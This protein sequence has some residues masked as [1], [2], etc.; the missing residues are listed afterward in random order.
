MKFLHDKSIVNDR[1]LAS[2]NLRAVNIFDLCKFNMS[3]NMF[4]NTEQVCS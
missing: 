4:M 1:V 3:Q 2:R